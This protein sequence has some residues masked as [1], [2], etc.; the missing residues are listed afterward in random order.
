MEAVRTGQISSHGELMSEDQTAWSVATITDP[1][2]YRAQLEVASML[3]TADKV[4]H[5][6]ILQ[7][8]IARKKKRL[9]KVPKPDIPDRERLE[10]ILMS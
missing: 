3:A 4:L 6:P 1:Q 8:L 7:K 9:P 10:R 2:A 5:R